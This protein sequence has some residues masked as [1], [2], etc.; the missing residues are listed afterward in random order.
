MMTVRRI[1]TNPV[2]ICIVDELPGGTIRHD[3]L[4]LSAEDALRVGQELIAA[5]TQHYIECTGGV[6]PTEGG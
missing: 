1:A 6:P 4:A 3:M 2:R 5:V